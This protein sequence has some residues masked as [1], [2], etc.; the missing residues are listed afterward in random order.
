[1][2][3]PLSLNILISLQLLLERKKVP[4]KVQET[5]SQLP[6]QYLSSCDPSFYLEDLLPQLHVRNDQ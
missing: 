5:T 6:V 1:M 4:K 3:S 2:L